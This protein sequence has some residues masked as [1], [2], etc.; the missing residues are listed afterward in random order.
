MITFQ[1]S[2]LE[3]TENEISPTKTAGFTTLQHTAFLTL[4]LL[5]N[6]QQM[7]ST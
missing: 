5:Q 7:F 1:E 2:Y 4:L 3:C 6:V